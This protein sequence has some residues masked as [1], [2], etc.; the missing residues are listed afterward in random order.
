MSLS[1]VWLVFVIRIQVLSSSNLVCVLVIQFLSSFCHFSLFK[2]TEELVDKNE[3]K[4][5]FQSFSH[6]PSGHTAAGQ[7][8]DIIWIHESPKFVHK[9]S[10]YHCS[11]E[12]HVLAGAKKFTPV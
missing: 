12:M 3:S 6:L 7:V 4:G 11:P 1:Y 5:G 2:L 10:K 9:F 8:L